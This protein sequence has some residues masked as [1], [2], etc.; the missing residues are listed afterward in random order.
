[1]PA[2]IVR[3]V[4]GSPY[5][6]CRRAGRNLAWVRGNFAIR[7]RPAMLRRA[8]VAFLICVAVS[9]ASAARADDWGVCKDENASPD[10]A[11][12]AC[13]RLIKT[14]R[15]KG[16]DLAITYYNR[17][18]SYRQKKDNESALADYN[19]SL[20][21]NPKYAKSYNNR[22]NVYKDKGDLDRAIADYN[23]AIRLDPKFALAYANRG[24]AWD[25]KN[26]ST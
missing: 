3:D 8:T 20:R 17:A 18:I 11:I 19:E 10:S 25:D 26:D 12:D 21:I 14:G 13:T 23:E 7:E 6:C 9:A 4:N 2:K 22:G 16:N 1:M 15:V 24:D 5:P